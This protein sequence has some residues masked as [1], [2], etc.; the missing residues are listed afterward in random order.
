MLIVYHTLNNLKKCSNLTSIQNFGLK[1]LSDY[2]DDLEFSH[3]RAGWANEMVVQC[4]SAF[5]NCGIWIASSNNRLDT[6][7]TRIFKDF[8]DDYVGKTSVNDQRESIWLFRVNLF[9]Y[10]RIIPLRKPN[11]LSM[12][13]VDD[14]IIGP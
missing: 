14:F 7:F 5:I 10:Q 3:G 1:D 8:S 9:H 13:M 2:L 11:D 6:S 4:S 12:I